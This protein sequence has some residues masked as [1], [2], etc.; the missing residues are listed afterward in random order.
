MNRYKQTGNN[1]VDRALQI[2]QKQIDDLKNT[3]DIIFGIYNNN[4]TKCGPGIVDNDFVRIKGKVFEGRSA[5]EVRSDIGAGTSSVDALN[6]LSDVTYSSGDLT[7]SS[8]DKI[9]FHTADSII[10]VEG[11]NDNGHDLTIAAGSPTTSV[12]KT[13]GDL[14][15]KAGGSTGDGNGGK[16]KIYGSHPGSS[17]SAIRNAVEYAT[18]NPSGTLTLKNPDTTESGFLKFYRDTTLIGSVSADAGSG[19]TGDGDNLLINAENTLEI[20]GDGGTVGIQDSEFQYASFI[21]DSNTTSTLKIHDANST[22]GHGLTLQVNASAESTISTTG[23]LAG[24]GPLSISPNGPLTL[25]SGGLASQGS[26]TLDDSI[27]IKEQADATDDTAGYVQLWVHDTTPCDLMFTDDAG[28]D[29]E[30]LAGNI[31][32]YTALLNDSADSSYTIT[33]SYAVPAADWKVTFVAPPSGNVEIFVSVYIVS[34]ATRQTYFGLSDNATYNTL[35]VT[36]EHRVHVGDETDEETLNHQ[37]VITG[38]TAGT[39]YTYFLGAK[40]AQAGRVSLKWGGDAA[41]EFAPFI[42]KA[43][44]LPATIYTG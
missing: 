19:T 17:G 34:T 40:N 3:T 12:N 44:A 6:D 28:N 13:G 41:D 2:I 33:A 38:L 4:V 9:N 29:R 20:S 14:H 42:M 39:S 27:K 11:D 7:I 5:A 23:A 25:A 18:F 1:T 24:L 10:E 37:W 35:D 32:G 43:T 22:G 31:L 15:L 26:I 36:H 21:Y 16:I 30:I 8:L